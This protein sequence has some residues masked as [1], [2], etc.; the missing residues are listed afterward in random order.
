M[1]IHKVLTPLWV[2]VAAAQN[3]AVGDPR[4][5]GRIQKIRG[6][7]QRLSSMI[8]ECLV[9]DRGASGRIELNPDI[10]ALGE[11]L[12]DVDGAAR[13]SAPAH[14]FKLEMAPDQTTLFGDHLLSEIAVCNQNGKASGRGRGGQYG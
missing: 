9:E 13:G 2:F 12:K 8:R 10:M 1:V 11:V 3:L 7:V 4:D 6:A 5:N 14:G